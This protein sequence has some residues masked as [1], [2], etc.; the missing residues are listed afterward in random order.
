MRQ[1]GPAPAH[2][3]LFII[4]VILR[5]FR[6]RVRRYSTGMDMNVFA[7]TPLLWI[8]FPAAAAAIIAVYDVRYRNPQG[9]R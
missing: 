9:R 2:L 1:P 8:L 7:T 6:W 5:T 4:Y 3:S